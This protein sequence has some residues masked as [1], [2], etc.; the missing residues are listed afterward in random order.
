MLIIKFLFKRKK[1]S[2]CIQNYSY[3]DINNSFCETKIPDI[4]FCSKSIKDYEFEFFDEILNNNKDSLKE[5][6]KDKLSNISNYENHYMEV[7]ISFLYEICK[8]LNITTSIVYPFN[9]ISYKNQLKVL[10]L[11]KEIIK[12]LGFNYEASIGSDRFSILVK[13]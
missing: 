5:F 7:Y 3:C 11:I 12:R 4:T 2:L 1:M 9:F 6:L 10:D 13:V 8:I